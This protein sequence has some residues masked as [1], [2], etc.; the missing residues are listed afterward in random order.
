[1]TQTRQ[2]TSRIIRSQPT[3]DNGTETYYTAQ[4]MVTITEEDFRSF[5]AVRVSGLVNMADGHAV[6]AASGLTVKQ[7]RA[8][9]EIYDVLADRFLTEKEVACASAKNL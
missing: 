6:E 8:I 7:I 9:R 4:T 2:E 1:M 3:L 5:E